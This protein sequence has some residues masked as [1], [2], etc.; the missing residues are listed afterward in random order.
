MTET[1]QGSP[2]RPCS[3]SG[4]RSRLR[5]GVPRPALV[6]DDVRLPRGRGR[7]RGLLAPAR[8]RVR[9]LVPGADQGARVDSAALHLV[10]RRRAQRRLQLPR[11]ARRGRPGR[12][13]R[14]PLGRRARRRD[15]RPH[16]RGS[17]ARG[18][19]AR[20]RRSGSS[21]S[22]RATASGSTWG[23][24]RSC[25]SRCSRARGS[26]RP[27]SS[28]SA[29]SRPSRSPSGCATRARR[30]LITQDEG[31]RKGAKVPL[32]ANADEAAAQ[33]P[34]IER[35]VVLRRTGD[36][37]PWNDARDVWWHDL[38]DDA[39]R[40]VRARADGRR[41]HALP[42]PHVRHDREAEGRAAHERRLPPARVGHAQVDLR[43]PRRLG[44]VV[45][46]RHRLGHRPLATSSTARSTTAR[47]A[48][49]T[50]ATPPTPT[51]TAT[52]R[53]SSATASAPTTRRRR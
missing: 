7:L 19:P 29:A 10:R 20:E 46:R 34:S 30:L 31:W 5:P 26:A 21:A 43:H 3:T 47:R 35:L 50:R 23:W 49:S 41:G 36:P 42:P 11:Q 12:P 17:A 32:K 25:R 15:A 52:G 45:R 16:L 8:A 6:P 14:L 44:L 40:V 38:V 51:G 53:S 28:S 1:T 27:T 48:S 9:R 18:L 13:G 39:A 24:S 37:V 2:S 33:A 4:E 22:A